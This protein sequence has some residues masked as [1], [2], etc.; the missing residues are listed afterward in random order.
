MNKGGPRSL[1][2]AFGVA[3]LMALSGCTSIL[4]TTTPATEAT[5]ECLNAAGAYF[6]PKKVLTVTVRGKDTTGGKL[7]GYGID[8]V[9]DWSSVPDR[10]QRYCLDYLGSITS[11]D[12]VGIVRTDQ[13][14]LKRIYTRAGD[15]SVAITKLQIHTSSLPA[16]AGARGG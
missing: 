1:C 9:D 5:V 14:L 10:D 16:Q 12:E 15:R 2:G 7:R 8:I 13:G 6:L 3:F 11:P 4:E